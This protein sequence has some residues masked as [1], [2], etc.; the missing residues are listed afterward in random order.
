MKDDGTGRDLYIL[1]ATGGTLRRLTNLPGFSSSPAW[2]PDGRTIYF[3][4]GTEDTSN[5]WK[6]PM[7]PETGLAK[8]KPQQV[9]FFKD[10]VVLAPQVLGDGSRICFNMIKLN[11]YLRVAETSSPQEAR[12]LVRCG[13]YSPELSPDGQTVYY[14][15]DT[16]GEEGIYAVPSQGGTPRQLTES[17]PFEVSGCD[18]YRRFDLSSDGRTL[19]YSAKLGNE[20]GLFTI[21]V[22]GGEPQLLVQLTNA[23]KFGTVPQW[24]PDGSQLAYTDGTD[25]NIITATGGQP[26]KLNKM[27]YLWE[28]YSVC[29]SLDGKFIA[30]LGILDPRKPN[31]VFAVPASGGE[32]R[33]LPSADEWK[34]G[35]EW[36]PDGQ[37]LTY[38][39]IRF[40]N[41]THQAYLDGREPTLLVNAPDTKDYVGTWAPD[42]RRYFFLCFTEG[43][44]MYVY[45]ESSGKTTQAIEPVE[46]AGVPCF[47]RDGKTM[48]W[49]EVR[50]T[51]M[52]AWIMEDFLPES[53]AGE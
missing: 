33:R 46:N 3:V 31:A 1:P 14:V 22:S 43:V 6:L 44:G 38:S 29:W 28:P 48:A 24:S 13:K 17:L 53:T 5:I 4:S 40:D 47:S 19:A 2:A 39:V 25:L 52:Q 9:T 49:W 11:T 45:D 41:E 20:P 32:L 36:H 12:S 30:A 50:K 26:R 23:M 35:L 15:N 27:S 42:G 18:Y 37:C 51:S 7:D 10:T 21:P 34:E 8:G 16:P